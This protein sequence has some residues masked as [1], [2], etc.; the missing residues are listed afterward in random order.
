MSKGGITEFLKALFASEGGGRISIEN[1]FGYIGK[2][3]FGEAALTDLGYYKGD[4]SSNRSLTGEFKQDW[5]GEWTGKNGAT[6]KDVFLSSEAAQDA[7]ARDWVAFLCKG[8]KRHKLAQYIGDTIGGVEITESGIIAGAHLK[9]FG[10]TTNPGVIQFLRSNGTVNGAD[11]FGTSV[12][13]YMAKFADYDLGCCEHVVV[14]LRDREKVPIPAL[15]YEIRAGTKIVRKGETDGRGL[16]RKIAMPPGPPV[17]EVFVLR[18]EGGMKLVA[19]FA[20]P[21]TSAIVTL[22]SPKTVVAA[23]LETH[24][25]EPG[26]YRAGRAAASV[27]AP[28]NGETGAS[29][30]RGAKGN[31]VAVA[32]APPASNRIRSG[33]AWE[34]QFPT[35]TSLCDLVPAFEKNV[36]RFIEAMKTAGIHV[37]IAATHRPKERAYLMHYC[38]KIADCQ[39]SPD[40]VPPMDGVD[41][42]WVHCDS[43]GKMDLEASR[44]AAGEM[45]EAYVIQFPAALSSRHTQRRAID[46]TITCFKDKTVRNAGGDD[47]AVCSAADLHA[48][49]ATYGVI[50]LLTDPP[51]WSDDGH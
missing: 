40:K 19:R 33:K 2:Y 17:F 13:A 38:C 32:H 28:Q 8:M 5:S 6:G 43:T 36:T 7:A 20:A 22:I 9:G 30:E 29:S 1:K 42:D 10:S 46:M 39:I 34:Q 21:A 47:V 3:Q 11:A 44:A 37:R 48:V 45:M 27:A 23:K 31:P 4:G 35:S 12:S 50:K 15:K 24:K 16:T 14:N 26:P 51:H 49:G 18:V 41:I 25:G